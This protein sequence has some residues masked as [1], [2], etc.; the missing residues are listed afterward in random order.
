MSNPPPHP[1]Q[2]LSR[3]LPSPSLGHVHTPTTTSEVAPV[4]GLEAIQMSS[5]ILFGQGLHIACSGSSHF[6]LLVNQC[7]KDASLRVLSL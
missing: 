2:P 3:P 1:P 5:M 7:L 6:F 4:I